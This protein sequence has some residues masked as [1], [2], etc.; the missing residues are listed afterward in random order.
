MS[1][2]IGLLDDV[3]VQTKPTRI[4]FVCYEE[5]LMCLFVLEYATLAI[6]LSLLQHSHLKL[7]T[8]DQK[9]QIFLCEKQTHIH[10]SSLNPP[11]R[12]TIISLNPPDRATT[13]SRLI[14]Q[15][16]LC[17]AFKREL[18]KKMNVVDDVRI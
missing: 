18:L 3:S 7:D 10:Q 13:I 16:I 2:R 4:H 8:L 6:N 12:A 1:E 14:T 11:D 17:L 5:M 9:E 15:S